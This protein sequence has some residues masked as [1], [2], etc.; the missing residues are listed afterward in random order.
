[1]VRPHDRALA[2]QLEH[3]L[4][5]FHDQEHEL[6][7]IHEAARLESF[8]EQLIE[9]IRREK[10]VSTIRDGDIS[11]RRADPNDELFNPL[12]A[13]ILFQRKG[14]LD[15]AFWMVFYFVHFGKNRYSGWRYARRV[16]GC[17]GDPERRWDW[18]STR[19]DPGGFRLWLSSHQD[20]IRSSGARGGFGN[21]RKY[22]RLDAYS[23]NG[24]GAAFET[25]IEW[26]GQQ[27]HEMLMDLAVRSANGN[28]RFAFRNLY[29]SMAK[30]ASFGRTARFDY[31]SMVSKLQLALIEPDSTYIQG[32]TGPLN[33]ARLLFGVQYGPKQLDEWLVE[34][35][36]QL[37][38]GMQV[39][40]DALC[41]WQKSP[42]R[43]KPFRG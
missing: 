10:Y 40:E 20:Q 6:P 37:G 17:L 18:E 43:F 1:M 13:A 38:I 3:G 35:E 36:A 2:S 30:V 11:E 16:Y 32:S 41:N 7:G 28:A 22:Q 21:H 23:S 33:G 42:S 26:V 9:S 12:K 4:W 24:T 25:Y 31:L 39:L 29:H 34:L 27:T 19:A 15:E 8:V 14:N 5:L